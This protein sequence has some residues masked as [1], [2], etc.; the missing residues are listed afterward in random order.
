MIFVNFVT[1]SQPVVFS[2]LDWL[3]ECHSSPKNHH[4][5]RLFLHVSH[6]GAR[7]GST[8][9]IG[10][11]DTLPETNSTSPL[12]IG[13]F[14]PKRERI[15]FI[16][17][18]TINVQGRAVSFREGNCK[19]NKNKKKTPFFQHKILPPHPIHVSKR[20]TFSAILH[21]YSFFQKFTL[22]IFTPTKWTPQKKIYIP[23]FFQESLQ[24]WKALMELLPVKAGESTTGAWLTTPLAED[25]D[26]VQG[27][28][29]RRR[30]DAWQKWGMEPKN[31]GKVMAKQ[32]E[33]HPP[34]GSLDPQNWLF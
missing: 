33:N 11:W 27:V 5:R 20:K 7:T 3:L 23:I 4:S 9:L 34:W 29:S 1:H 21:P 28:E 22:Y 10:K 25:E 13:E 31:P 6:P 32:P 30:G 12:K 24:A 26:T 19:K 8:S 17:Q 16:F 2:P 14:F 18:P 15:K